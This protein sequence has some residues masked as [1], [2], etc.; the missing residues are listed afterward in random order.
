MILHKPPLKDYTELRMHTAMLTT[1]TLGMIAE[2]LRAKRLARE[3]SA[4]RAAAVV[5]P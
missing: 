4:A 1:N 3:A 2:K 5:K